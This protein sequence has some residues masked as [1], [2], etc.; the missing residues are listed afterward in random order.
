MFAVHR[1][2][3]N[4]VFTGFAHHNLARHHENFLARHGE[5]FARFNRGER[6]SQ[7]AIEAGKDLAVASKEILVMAGSLP[8][9]IA[10]SAGR[11]PPVPT[12]ATRTISAF[13]RQAILRSPS[14]PIKI[15]G[16]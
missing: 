6:W 8:A 3:M 9:S 15:R 16:S 14:S 2:N 1:Q 7:S 13:V 11:N 12:I 4:A 5:I 10:A